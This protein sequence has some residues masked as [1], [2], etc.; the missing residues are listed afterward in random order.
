MSLKIY[1]LVIH[2][3]HKTLE[4]GC[5]WSKGS[6]ERLQGHHGPL[7]FHGSVLGQE[8]SELQPSIG[9][10]LEKHEYVSCIHGMTEIMLKAV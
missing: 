4:I 8:T 7:V 10:T 9:E 1:C 2:I 5:A 6:G 3:S